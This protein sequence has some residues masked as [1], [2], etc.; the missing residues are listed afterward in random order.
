[1][2]DVLDKP[3][4]GEKVDCLVGLTAVSL[5]ARMDKQAVAW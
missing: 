2:V 4:V 5:V 1:M 3:M